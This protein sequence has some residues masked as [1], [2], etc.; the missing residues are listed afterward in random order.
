MKVSSIF[1]KVLMAI[2][3]IGLIG[4]LV[5]HLLGNLSLFRGPQTFNAYAQMLEDQKILL[6][7]AEIGL[8]GIFLMHVYLAL[9]LT[10]EN[11]AARPVNYEVRQ[12]AGQ[13]SFSS[14]TMWY[15]GIVI[16]IFIVVHIWGMKFGVRPNESLWELVV[17]KF[18][19]PGIAGFYI[20]CMAVLGFHLGHGIGSVFQSL[21]LRD[22][23]GRPT[24]RGLA[25]ILGW[26]LALG[27]AALPIWVLVAKPA[28]SNYGPQMPHIPGIE[29][30]HG[31]N[32]RPSSQP[33]T[34][35][36]IKTAAKAQ[37]E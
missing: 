28:A 32:E 10:R 36:N 13:S 3:G 33:S 34:A 19:D 37:V 11:A 25:P 20:V 9:T 31:E 7:I 8:L 35:E 30:K 5:T 4:F 12:T 16:F 21:G 14:R 27:F 1:K 23:S 6:P 2:T 24:L 26:A 18:S 22:R 17:T 29:I 15:T